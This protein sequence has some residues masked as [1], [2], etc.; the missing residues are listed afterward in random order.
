MKTFIFNKKIKMKSAVQ[1]IA[2]SLIF[3]ETLSTTTVGL[4]KT[5]MFTNK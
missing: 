4:K 3:T 1:K 2:S 5:L